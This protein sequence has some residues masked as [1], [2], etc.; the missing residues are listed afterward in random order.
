[1]KIRNRLRTLPLITAA[2]WEHVLTILIPLA[3]LAA[4]ALQDALFKRVTSEP[5]FQIAVRNDLRRCPQIAADLEEH[6][7]AG[8]GITDLSF[9]GIRIELKF[10]DSEL[11]TLKRCE[12][13]TEQTASYIVASGKRIGILCVLD[14]SPKNSHAFP[15]EEGIG[16]LSRP[17]DD[18]EIHIVTVIIQGNLA[19]PSDLSK[20]A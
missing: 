17:T 2:D 13:F 19:R 16:I 9:H 4:R 10:E 18:A 3:G 12:R 1:M 7:H 14:N 20:R 8:G 6:P 11:M 15:A 5:Q